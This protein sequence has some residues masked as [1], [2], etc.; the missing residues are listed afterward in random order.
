[1][2]RVGSLRGFPSLPHARA[3][4]LRPF[5]L[6][7]EPLAGRLLGDDERA[8]RRFKELFRLRTIPLGQ[9]RLC[10]T[11]LGL[12]L[13]PAVR[14]ALDGMGDGRCRAGLTGRLLPEP[15]LA[16][17]PVYLLPTCGF[18]GHLNGLTG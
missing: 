10:L 7:V 9:S 11:K 14:C 1:M 16:L 2:R 5:A 12:G 4:C 8:G 6:P 15:N 17:L 3:N 13:L 18:A